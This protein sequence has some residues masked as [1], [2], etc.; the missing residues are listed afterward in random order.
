M[1]RLHAMV[2]SV[3]AVAAQV[4][5]AALA[6]SLAETARQRA[7]DQLNRTAMQLA[8]L[9]AK[10]FRCSSLAVTEGRCCGGGDE[11]DRFV[12]DDGIEHVVARLAFEN[13]R[14]NAEAAAIDM[15][16]NFPVAFSSYVF[17]PHRSMHSRGY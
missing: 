13:Y 8:D 12:S 5:T 11:E 14:F 10:Q 3:A 4:E 7:V 6:V 17:D 16:D 15:F 9:E 1:D 2:E